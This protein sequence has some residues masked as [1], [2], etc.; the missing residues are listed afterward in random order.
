MKK[1]IWLLMKKNILIYILCFVFGFLLHELI[2]VKHRVSVLE[3]EMV[4]VEEKMGV[5][6]GIANELH[7]KMDD[8]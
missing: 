6:V 7:M 5:V 1:D 4:L 3:N 8:Y 2:D